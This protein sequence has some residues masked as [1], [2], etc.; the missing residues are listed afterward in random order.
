MVFRSIRR[1]RK[2]ITV[3]I[4]YTPNEN[5]TIKYDVYRPWSVSH[6][7]STTIRPPVQ[8]V[9]FIIEHF[10]FTLMS[11][12]RGVQN[13]HHRHPRLPKS[14]EAGRMTSDAITVFTQRR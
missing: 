12:R 5:V 14:H 8:Q 11:R 2:L 13:R 1:Y 10:I 9:N 7:I 3:K 4:K 6:I